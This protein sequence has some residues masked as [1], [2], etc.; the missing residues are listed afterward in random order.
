MAPVDMSLSFFPPKASVTASI[1][2]AR[3]YL[4][5]TL[6]AKLVEQRGG[7]GKEGA[8]RKDEKSKDEATG[9]CV[10]PEFGETETEHYLV[11][12]PVATR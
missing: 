6:Q 10:W 7:R 5:S 8:E 9:G 4:N 11:R 12:T 2:N 3:S 1:Y